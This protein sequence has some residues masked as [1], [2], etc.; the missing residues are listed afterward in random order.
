MFKDQDKLIKALVAKEIIGEEKFIEVFVN[1]PIDECV[2]R[3]P[4]G[5]YA[6]AK[7]GE[8]SKFTGVGQE[9]ESP[10]NPK[11]EIDTSK[12]TIEK[13]VQKILNFLKK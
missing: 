10:E 2:K 3:D 1:T 12:E 6:K 4:K 9:Y 11:I 5:L 7:K 13:S 8:I